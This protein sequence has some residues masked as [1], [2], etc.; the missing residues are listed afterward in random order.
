[1]DQCHFS[2]FIFHFSFF[3]FHFSTQTKTAS[4]VNKRMNSNRSLILRLLEFF[5]YIAL[6]MVFF[7]LVHDFRS[8]ISYISLLFLAGL[9]FVSILIALRHGA[10]A[11]T[12]LALM[13]MMVE[14][15][16][17]QFTLSILF[18]CSI[19]V[20]YSTISFALRHNGIDELLSN[21]SPRRMLRIT[22]V[23][24]VVVACILSTCLFLLESP[25]DSGFM[26]YWAKIFLI[27][28]LGPILAFRAL[29]LLR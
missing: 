20:S 7:L 6:V 29:S 27:E 9:K 17:G 21:L 23:N 8:A 1:M 12:A 19:K 16:W 24:A 13:A 26:V 3:I 25:Q 5:I 4:M 10:L 22:I 18:L 11:L 15:S 28:L 14:N 2:F